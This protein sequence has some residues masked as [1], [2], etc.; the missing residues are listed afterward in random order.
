ML[1]LRPAEKIRYRLAAP[2]EPPAG[3]LSRPTASAGTSL[4]T[5]AAA[6]RL[7]LEMTRA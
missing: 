6:G 2:T 7:R 1:G 4:Q 5:L 3:F